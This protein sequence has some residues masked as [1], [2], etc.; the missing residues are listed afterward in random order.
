[1]NTWG[2]LAQSILSLLA[3][4][5]GYSLARQGVL[6]GRAASLVGAFD[7]RVMGRRVLVDVLQI[8]PDKVYFRLAV[9]PVN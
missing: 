8:R 3:L 9:L 7:L 1:M 4:L 2:I 6:T 5:A